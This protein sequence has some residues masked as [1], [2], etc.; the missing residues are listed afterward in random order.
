MN[1]EILKGTIERI[2]FENE[3]SGYTIARLSSRDYPNELVT[4]IGNLASVSPG[5]SVLL[6]GFWVNN[7]KYG[8]QF[9]IEEYETIMPA[10]IMGI[11]K[12]LGSGLVKGVGPVM[13]G[14]IVNYFGLDTFEVIEKNPKKLRSVKG[15]GKKRIKSIVKAW[16]EQREI[17]DVM[18]FLQGHGV[19]T[20]YA[21]K[22]Y[23]TYES[24]AINV[25][26]EDPYRLAE[27][28]YGIGFKTADTIAQNLGMEKHA[29]SR[30][31]SGIKYVLG[32]K[33]D[34]GHVYV[35]KQELIEACSE[36][37]DVA[38]ELIDT[39]ITELLQKEE[40]I[41][42]DLDTDKAIYLAPF[43]YAEVGV[44]NKISVLL[45]NRNKNKYTNV[46]LFVEQ[47]ES[48]TKMF[49]SEKQK[50][51]IKKALT[52]KVLI[53]TG[54]PGTGKTTAV[55]GMIKLFE[56]FNLRIT[57]ASPTGRAAKRLSEVT[58]YEAKTIHRLLEF[59]PQSNEFKRNYENPLETDVVIIDEMSMVDIILMNNLV[60]AIPKNAI[61]I[62]VGDVDQLPSVGAG[63][64][65]KD[66]IDS[67]EI[68][69]VKLTQI[70]RQASKSLIITNAH[71]INQGEFPIVTGNQNRDF[72]FIEE[73]E[74]EAV[75]ELIQ[76]IVS[77]R[78]PDYYN[79]HSMDD[80][81]V[82]CPMR[83]GIVGTN[84]LNEFLQNALNPEGQS[85]GRGGRN[86]RVGDKVMQIRNNY[87]YEVFNGDIGRIVNFDHIQKEVRIKYPEKTVRY[88]IADLFELEL[89]YATTIHKAQGSEYRAI[90]MPLLTQHYMLLQRNLLYTGITRAKELVV[91][92]GTKKALGMAIR[93]NKIAKRYTSLAKRIRTACN[94]SSINTEI[95]VDDRIQYTLFDF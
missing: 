16:E 59:S 82:L 70:F 26:R 69:M 37:L 46:E 45:K 20:A 75:V 25:V 88:D 89:A 24:K 18:V 54:G 40:V 73:G 86:F 79:Y 23:K 1:M 9:K 68:D 12:Y 76:E 21:V 71:R 13:A 36:I 57:L 64:V 15:I 81:Q 84:K 28:V 35:P 85:I 6:K 62:M 43:Y 65:L 80:I 27:D 91:L 49:Y 30:I 58:G 52:S 19:S 29:P 47:L 44:S 33:A 83:R 77:K 63:N 90:V 94:D 78:L 22:I 56:K 10:T 31:A 72:F 74:P 17:K 11:R 38:P 8:R 14:R 51:A 53:L 87:D 4:V 67:G 7:P 66:L 34:D 2:V 39:S 93:N 61:F 5:E 60:K 42:E 41:Q 48:S 32:K 55:L 50:E 92:I 95:E 3:E